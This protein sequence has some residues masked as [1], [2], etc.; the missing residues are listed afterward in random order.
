M[1]K[2]C[3]QYKNR[4]TI[5][6]HLPHKNI[7]ELKP[8]DMVHVDLIDPYSKSTRQNHPGGTVGQKNA[9][10]TCMTMIALATGW[11]EVV[12]IPKFDLEEVTIG[13]DEYIDK[14]S[15]RVSQLFNNT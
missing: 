12:K 1:C 3:Q 6:G 9:S 10:L 13:N 14:S 7:A 8:W 11:F 4:K 2:T 5:Y 15:A